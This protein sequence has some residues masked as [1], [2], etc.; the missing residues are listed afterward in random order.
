MPACEWQR[1]CI[2]RLTTL[3]SDIIYIPCDK[4]LSTPIRTRLSICIWINPQSFSTF[5]DRTTLYSASL[6]VP[7][8]A[9]KNINSPSSSLFLNF[10]CQ[11]RT[12]TSPKKRHVT[13]PCSLQL[14][15]PEGPTRITLCLPNHGGPP[16]S[17]T[18]ITIVIENFDFFHK[19]HIDTA[20][21]WWHAL[22]HIKRYLRHK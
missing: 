4:H 22:N 18:F 19:C 6:I 21:L 12:I 14:T 9:M 15:L 2:M 20:R 1:T 5:D 7:A 10:T 16:G 3:F 8:T 17:G 11:A 13:T